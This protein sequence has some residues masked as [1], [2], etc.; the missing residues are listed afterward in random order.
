M[1]GDIAPVDYVQRVQRALVESSPTSAGE[2]EAANATWVGA[3]GQELL[4][5]L[6]VYGY[7]VLG[8]TLLLGPI[9]LL[10]RR[11]CPPSSRARWLPKASSHSDG[12]G[13]SP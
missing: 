12:S 5:A 1:Q 2:T 9:G 4:A 3:V 10:C 11:A 7:P 8:L 6:L 13:L